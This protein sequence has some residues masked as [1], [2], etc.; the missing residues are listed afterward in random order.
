MAGGIG[1]RRGIFGGT[2]DPPHLG[3]LIMAESARAVLDLHEVVFVPAAQPPHKQGRTIQPAADRLAMV[4]LAIA[5]NP[6]FA[7][8]TLELERTGPNYTVETLR[9]LRQ[10]WGEQVELYFIMGLDSLIDLPLWYQP[11]EIIKLARLAVITRPGYQ[12]DLMSLETALP[13]VQ[14][15]VALVPSPLI[16]ISSTELRRRVFQ[17]ETITYLV[18]QMVEGYIYQHGL[19]RHP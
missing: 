3:H 14:E 18:P 15:R 2:F 10:Q 4:R 13:G 11:Q 9:L 5:S 17:G 7:L 6:H 1:L 16:G 12:A 19:Y 8:S